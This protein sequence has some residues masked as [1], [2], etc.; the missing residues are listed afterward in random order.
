MSQVFIEG[1]GF[2]SEQMTGWPIAQQVL[3]GELKLPDTR[4]RRPGPSSLAAAERRRAP[5]TVCLAMQCADEAVSA[6]GLNASELPCVFASTHGDLPLTDY[7][8]ETVATD[9]TAISPTRFHNSVHNAPAGY[10]TI[11]AHAR[12]ASTALAAY[13]STFGAGLLEAIVQ[14]TAEARPLLFV[15]YDVQTK[16]A[17][18]EVTSSEGLLAVALVLS[19]ARTPASRFA[20]S[21]A[22]APA[23]VGHQVT[24][25]L[26][27]AAEALSGNALNPCLPLFEAFARETGT[28]VTLSAGPQLTLNLNLQPGE[29]AQ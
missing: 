8:C 3:A 27:V 4:A 29:A 9:A 17:L 14:C 25:A 7:L 24:G 22:L 20:L 21:W 15:A 12:E 5:D 1:I 26:S 2:W 6:S 23:P 28:G 11:A 16:G 19:P 18:S 10:W 13:D